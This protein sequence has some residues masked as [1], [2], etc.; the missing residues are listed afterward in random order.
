MFQAHS[1]TRGLGN[2]ETSVQGA[3]GQ[4]GF[5]KDCHGKNAKHTILKVIYM[6]N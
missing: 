6:N 4:K 2:I 3:D 5:N 1:G